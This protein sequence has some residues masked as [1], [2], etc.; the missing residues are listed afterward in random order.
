MLPMKKRLAI[1]LCLL[2][3]LPA[4]AC[5]YTGSYNG[6]TLFTFSYDSARYRMDRDSYLSSNRGNQAWF[7][8]LYDDTYS[9]D[10]GMFTDGTT[11]TM[12]NGDLSE[13]TPYLMDRY[14]RY[15]V[16]DQGSCTVN[17]Q[18]YAL[19]LLSDVSTGGSYFAATV[20][21]G[22][23][24]TFEI[25]SMSAGSVDASALSTLKSVLSGCYPAD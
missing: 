3:C 20:I 4:L 25:Y 12:S 11:Q 24:V 8:L 17:G 9:I 18:S 23:V 15:G 5:A 2:L 7:F 19:F 16:S 1:M 21:N 22:C 6:S 10:C 14:A 13:L